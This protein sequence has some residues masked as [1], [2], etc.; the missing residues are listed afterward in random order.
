[1]PHIGGVETHIQKLAEE[2]G[3]DCEV[4]VVTERDDPQSEL[5]E[6]LG[7]VAVLRIPIPEQKT[8]KVLI[9]WWWIK[10]LKLLF[11]A[12]IIHIHDVFFWFLPFRGLFFWK[13]VFMTFHG[14]EGTQNPNWKQKFWHQ[15]AARCTTGNLCI[16]GFH[17][18]WYGVNPDKVSYGAVETNHRN[19]AAKKFD[20]KR[21][22]IIKI[23]FVGRLAADTGILTYLAAM[24]IIQS[25]HQVSLDVFGD[26][27]DLPYAKKYVR[28][29]HLNVVFHGFLPQDQIKW[30]EF[31]VAF[32]SRYLAILESFING[33]P[34]IAQY[35][36]EIKKDYLKLSPFDKWLIIAETDLEIARGFEQIVNNACFKMTQ[37]AREW[38]S[39]QTWSQ[40]ASVYRNLWQKK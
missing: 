19:V 20:L 25:H 22:Q 13:P 33:I 39:Q 2:L 26:G 15:V 18:K 16:G 6:Q 38:A 21:R 8:S 10:H 34:V 3:A 1:M 9:W 4:T 35:A 11:S 23:V 27:P 17:Q 36:V 12:D 24:K 40:L 31:Q 32:V 7:M 14:Y 30:S 37:S 5:K 28:I 29:H